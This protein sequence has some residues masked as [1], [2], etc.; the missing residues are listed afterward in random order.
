VSLREGFGLP[1]LEAMAQGTPVV[2]SIGTATE[3]VA[4]DAALVVDPY[5]VDAITGALDVVLRDPSRAEQLAEAG[6][7]RAEAHTWER[8]AALMADV[9]AEAA[10]R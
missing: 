2:T 3:E 10:G 8:T 9:Y 6:R 5:D 7:A 1:V 4:G